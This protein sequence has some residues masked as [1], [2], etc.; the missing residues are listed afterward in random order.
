LEDIF[1]LVRA[2]KQQLYHVILINYRRNWWHHNF[3]K[4]NWLA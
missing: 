4:N 1:G 2:S 3:S